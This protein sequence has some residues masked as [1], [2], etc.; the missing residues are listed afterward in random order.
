[1]K[2]KISFII[3]TDAFFMEKM[4]LKLISTLMESKQF[5]E[6]TV[7]VRE[8]KVSILYHLMIRTS[9]YTEAK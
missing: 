8:K 9:I 6:Y 5:S 7:D 3:N 2:K 1:M 4:P